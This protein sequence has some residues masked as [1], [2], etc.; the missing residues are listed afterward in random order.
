MEKEYF[1]IGHYTATSG[2]Y[3][4]KVGTTKDLE[5]RRKQHN[6]YYKSTPNYPKA[7]EFEYDFYLPLS[8]YNT[9]RIEDRTREQLKTEG[10]GKFVRNDRF[11]FAEKPTQ[12]E[13][14]VRKTYTIE[15]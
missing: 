8:K 3:V 12:I 10:I 6:N 15:L 2:E 1:Y 7:T 11:V 14:T 5:E 4:L 13:I 9:H